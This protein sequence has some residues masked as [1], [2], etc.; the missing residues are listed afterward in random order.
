MKKLKFKTLWIIVISLILIYLIISI[1]SSFVFS[2][3]IDNIYKSKSY[4]DYDYFIK[5]D[6][7]TYDLLNVKSGYPEKT[8][9]FAYETFEKTFPTI[10]LPG[11]GQSAFYFEYTYLQIDTQGQKSA[12][13]IQNYISGFF[14]FSKGKLCVTPNPFFGKSSIGGTFRHKE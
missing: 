4:N 2:A 11:I 9:E 3:I 7:E 5:I 10:V 1:F 6:Q 8:E 14:T 12:G 13:T